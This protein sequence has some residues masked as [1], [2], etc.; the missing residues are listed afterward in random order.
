MVAHSE[1]RREEVAYRRLQREAERIASLIVASDYAAVDVVIAIRQLKEFVEAEF[2]GTRRLFEM[3]Y[4]GR[5]KRLWEQ[6]REQRDGALPE[7]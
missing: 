7:W 4:E 6:F 5:F 3:V 1:A 2:P